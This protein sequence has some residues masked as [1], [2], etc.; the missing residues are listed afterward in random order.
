MAQQCFVGPGAIRLLNRTGSLKVINTATGQQVGVFSGV[1]FNGASDPGE[2]TGEVLISS[3]EH[4]IDYDDLWG[5]EGC[6][7]PDVPVFDFIS[8]VTDEDLDGLQ[9]FEFQIL[10]DPATGQRVCLSKTRDPE[11]GV[12]T[13]AATIVGTTDPYVGDVQTLVDCN[14][15]IEETQGCRE[16]TVAGAWGSV[17][18]KIDH[19]RWFDTAASPPSLYAEVFYNR[20]TLSTVVGIDGTNSVPCD[21]QEVIS[22]TKDLCLLDGP[23]PT[24][25]GLYVIDPNDGEIKIKDINCLTVNTLPAPNPGVPADGFFGVAV[26]PD[27]QQLWASHRDPDNGNVLRVWDVSIDPVNPVLIGDAIVFGIDLTDGFIQALDFNPVDGKLYALTYSNAGAPLTQD[28]KI[29]EIDTGTGGAIL[30]LTIPTEYNGGRTGFAFDENGDIWTVTDEGATFKVSQWAFPSGAFIQSPYALTSTDVAFIDFIASGTE[31]YAQLGLPSQ[32]DTYNH[33]AGTL[34]GVCGISEGLDLSLLPSG[35]LP[36]STKFKRVFIKD[37]ITDTVR[38]QNHDCITGD[39]IDLSEVPVEQITD[40]PGESTLVNVGN[41]VENLQRNDQQYTWYKDDNAGVMT[42]FWRVTRIDPLS[43][44]IQLVGNYVADFSANYTPTGAQSPAVETKIV[45]EVLI[46]PVTYTMNGCVK[47]ISVRVR[48]LVDQ[49]SPIRIGDAD[50]N[51]TTL[52]EGEEE[53]FSIDEGI[54]QVPAFSQPFTVTLPTVGDE[55]VITRTEIV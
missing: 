17:G 5:E 12:V 36:T 25:A 15:D 22:W 54:G 51:S 9:D 41:I 2:R 11:T 24:F 43:A 53:S 4:C 40:C 16:V 13:T 18:D 39:D 28:Y 8:D 32:L 6:N 31:L 52:L 30:R 34:I 47:S 3:G 37:L 14:R 21:K 50:A 23:L 48:N 27:V 46:G 44:A 29:Y 19:V 45:R 26:S 35:P 38:V 42:Y 20:N 10:C 7:C 1:R 55:V 33:P 49:N